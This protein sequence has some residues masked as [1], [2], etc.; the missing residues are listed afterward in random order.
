[1][2]IDFLYEELLLIIYKFLN[3]GGGERGAMGNRTGTV[4][5]SCSVGTRDRVVVQEVLGF[6]VWGERGR[7]GLFEERKRCVFLDLKSVVWLWRSGYEK[8]L[9]YIYIYIYIY[10]RG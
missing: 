3:K 4:A 7:C 2:T 10:M 5:C 1:M 6:G 9:V 8:G